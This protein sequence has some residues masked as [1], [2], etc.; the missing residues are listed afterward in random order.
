M[1]SADSRRY[2]KHSCLPDPQQRSHIMVARVSTK[3]SVAI[4]PDQI[5]VVPVPL[6]VVTSQDLPAVVPIHPR[7]RVRPK[8]RIEVRREE[9]ERPE[10][11]LYYGDNFDWLSNRAVFP[12][13]TVDL[14]YLD[15]PF[16]SS[17][18]YNLLFKEPSGHVAPSQIQ[19]F[20]D[21]WT[22]SHATEIALDEMVHSGP[23]AIRG[24]LPTL[25]GILD[26][27]ALSAYLVMMSQRLIELHRVLKRSGT[28]YL[29][30]DPT[31][32]HYLK[33][34]LDAIFG[35]E[36]FLNE[37]SWRR[38]ASHNDAKQGLTR[39][40][41]VRDVIL[42]YAKS[43]GRVWNQLYTAYDP[44][45]IEKDYKHCDDDG[46]QF[47]D[48]DLTAAKG[49]GDTEYEWRV[50]RL[51][52]SNA[53]WEADL[54]DEFLRPRSGWEYRGI[55]PYNNRYWSINR[56]TMSK[57][58]KEG[59]IFH[60]S[61][62]MPRQKLYADE[63][64]GIPLQDEWD[65]IGAVSGHESVHY[66]TQ[67]PL[68]LLERIISAS[69]NPGDVVLDPFCGCGTAVI[70]AEKLGRRW[71][72]IDIT[73]L[74]IGVMERRLERVFDRPPLYEVVGLP[75]DMND[76]RDFLARKGPYQFQWWI[77]DKLGAMPVDG[78]NKKGADHGIDGIITFP[79]PPTVRPKQC[80]IQVK[81]G[82]NISERDVRD[83]YGAIKARPDAEIG[84]LVTL[85]K[86]KDTMVRAA[87]RMGVYHSTWTGRD[88]PCIQILSVE[89]LLARKVPD[90]P[91]RLALPRRGPRVA[92]ERVEQQQLL[93][94]Q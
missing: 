33:L 58:A 31:I 1:H 60:R 57:L 91:P 78:R 27:N 53:R 83:L 19:A 59:R 76:A 69:S 26:K 92:A 88:Y 22:W 35:P 4:D 65:D 20:T 73:S 2:D 38:S 43:S 42:V 12:D 63:M 79:D 70:A 80:V 8:S 28:L 3:G 32:S 44:K 9:P 21:T 51:M 48:S 86:P 39:Y 82:T 94:V 85:E 62:G 55:R 68:A 41:R 89:D 93:T 66:A 67:K 64:P 18:A 25:C 6:E 11:Y 46:R 15:P 61:T 72:G 13:E 30:C 5:D 90:L 37:I 47:D 45:Y 81:S 40:G 10:R 16:N 52:A 54:D 71:I 17:R 14:V 29:H 77:A 7:A 74:A 87:Q 49:G 23:L 36:K 34:I 56:A 75:G 24:L 50:K 84:V